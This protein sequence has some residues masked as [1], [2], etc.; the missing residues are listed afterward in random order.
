MPKIY[1][2]EEVLKISAKI[3]DKRKLLIGNGFS[4]AWD[5]NIFSY[6]SLLGKAKEGKE[7]KKNPEIS[8]MFDEFGSNDFER[9]IKVLKDGSKIAK[10]YRADI[11]NDNV[12]KKLLAH[13]RKLKKILVDVITH[14][15]PDTTNRVSNNQ[16]LSCCEFLKNFE[17]IYSLNYDLLLYWA[18]L[19]LPHCGGFT[20]GFHEGSPGDDYV[21]WE[22]GSEIKAKLIYLHGALHL[23]DSENEIRKFTW[24]RTDKP[25][26]GQIITALNQD[27]FPI[28]VAEGASKEKMEVILH[29]AYLSRSFSS[30]KKISGQLFVFGFSFK[31]NDE[32]IIRVIEEGRIEHIFISILKSEKEKNKKQ[33]FSRASFMESRREA[34]R[35]RS[36]KVNSL[37]FYYFDAESAKVWS[38]K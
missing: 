29:N 37:R 27:M 32:H 3:S 9:I 1:S 16:K 10:V 30:F 7:F 5:R 31:D 15:H 25:L 38:K 6:G 24:V 12:P 23:F 13:S 35:K 21:V 14:N 28:I 33:I 2:F 18:I 34:L 11:K 4:C 36:N 22:I 19:N 26:K 17:C 8:Q 20:D